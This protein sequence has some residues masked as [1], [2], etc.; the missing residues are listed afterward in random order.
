MIAEDPPQPSPPPLALPVDRWPGARSMC[1]S[2]GQIASKLSQFT[3]KC[4]RIK[5]ILQPTQ[6]HRRCGEYLGVSLVYQQNFESSGPT[7]L[8]S[9]MIKETVADIIVR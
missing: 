5:P 2:S 6:K 3:Q 8:A 4:S 9:A 7:G 1:L